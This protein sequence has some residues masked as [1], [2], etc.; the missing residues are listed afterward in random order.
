MGESFGVFHSSAKE[1]VTHPVFLN[2]GQVAWRGTC[3]QREAAGIFQRKVGENIQ[4]YSIKKK[5]IKTN[6]DSLRD[7]GT[8]SK[9]PTFASY[10]N[11]KSETKGIKTYLKKY[12]SRK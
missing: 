1:F 4:S 10:Q 5:K 6:E 3:G 9:V 8:T 11:Q 7:L 12:W 2:D